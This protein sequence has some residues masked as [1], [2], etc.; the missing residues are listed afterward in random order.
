MKRKTTKEIIAESFT[1]LYESGA[2]ADGS[3]L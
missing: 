1:E 2:I 3:F